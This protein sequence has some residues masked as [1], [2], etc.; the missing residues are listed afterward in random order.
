MKNAFNIVLA[1]ICLFL[2]FSVSNNYNKS[3]K[4]FLKPMQKDIVN[5]KNDL[6]E[7]A[8]KISKLENKKILLIFGA[9]WCV[10][11]QKFEHDTLASLRSTNALES[12]KTIP[13]KINIENE[14]D[15]A[16]KYNIKSIPS[17]VIIDKEDVELKRKNGYMNI[18]E[19]IGWLD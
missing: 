19:F 16:Q 1:S 15:I 7:N 17:F 14:S 8:K 12:H 9:P 18:R 3:E 10:W 4:I 6:L 13:I 5:Q 11:C 2:I